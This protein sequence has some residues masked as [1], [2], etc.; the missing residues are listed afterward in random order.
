MY[1]PERLIEN[2]SGYLG[3]LEE[4]ISAAVQADSAEKSRLLIEKSNIETY[5]GKLQALPENHHLD[6]KHIEA[7]LALEPHPEGGFYREFIRT[8]ARTVIF[9]LLPEQAISSWHS[10]KDTQ[11]RFRLISGESLLIPKI[12]AG[13]LWKSEEAVT[14]EH[15]VVIEKN[16]DF[17]DW[18][19]A[20]PSGEYG[21]VTCECRGPFE[22]A[23]F[24][25]IDQGNLAA[26]HGK[27][28]GHAKTI[29]R[30]SPKLG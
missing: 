21:L 14:Y 28:P 13:G 15:D 4:L 16:Q 22:F 17:G 1:S 6:A 3:E 9:Y 24:K 2:L 8:D 25:I 30:L 5:V 18:F 29:D 26:F 23:K 20:Y 7:G 27:N 12:D 11:E 19:G 10:L